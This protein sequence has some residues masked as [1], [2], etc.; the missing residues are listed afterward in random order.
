M[1]GIQARIP[2]V[3][4]YNFEQIMNVSHFQLPLLQNGS[5]TTHFARLL[6]HLKEY[7]IAYI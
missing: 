2:D 3:L 4:S 1:I 5:N 6:L 7:E